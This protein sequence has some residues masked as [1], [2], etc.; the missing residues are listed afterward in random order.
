MNVK[1]LKGTRD[2]IHVVRNTGV[3][4]IVEYRFFY[5][6]CLACVTNTGQ[7]TQKEYA[8]PWEKFSLIPRKKIDLKK[9]NTEEWFQPI[10]NEI[11]NP[12]DQ[13]QE[14]QDEEVTI[15][16]DEIEEDNESDGEESNSQR[17]E[18]GLNTPQRDESEELSSK[19]DETGSQRDE[20]GIDESEELS[21]KRDETG[22]QR[23]ETGI[24]DT[25]IENTQCDETNDSEEDDDLIYMFTKEYES[26]ECP[27][28]DEE[29]V[30]YAE[31]LARPLME[32]DE[33]VNFD[34]LAILADMATYSSFGT[35]SDFVK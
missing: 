32:D 7:C 6:A 23:D 4:G 24:D 34:W 20:T 28:S 26:S 10:Y 15:H 2:N 31:E 19:R 12:V 1:Q 5:C 27:S 22:S 25:E 3:E 17:D 14:F 29:D 30:M 11:Y 16:C 35:L 21:S 9:I 8:D 18:T 33:N 13:I